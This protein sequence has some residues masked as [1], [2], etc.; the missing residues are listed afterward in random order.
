M[1]LAVMPAVLPVNGLNL[2]VGEASATEL[3]MGLI[4]LSACCLYGGTASACCP[5]LC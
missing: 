3:E 5:L 2:T 4:T 1:W